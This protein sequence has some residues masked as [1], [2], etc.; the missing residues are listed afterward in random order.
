MEAKLFL[1]L[2]QNSEA[3]T[4]F[5]TAID[6]T[7]DLK[8]QQEIRQMRDS[9]AWMIYRVS[10][11]LPSNKVKAIAV[12]GTTVWVG[13]SKGLT[14]ADTSSAFWEIK[15]EIT[16]QLEEMFEGSPLNIQSL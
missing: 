2:H 11:G 8:L 6:M 16:T 4:D 15:T 12:D 9:S 5:T 7:Q 14:E 13:T 10:D 1:K 3:I